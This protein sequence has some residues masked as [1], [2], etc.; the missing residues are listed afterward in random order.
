[1]ATQSA[2][3]FTVL[4]TSLN[5]M[6]SH[7]S[8][9]SLLLLTPHAVFLSRVYY[10]TLLTFFGTD[11]VLRFLFPTTPTSSQPQ[12]TRISIFPMVAFLVVDFTAYLWVVGYVTNSTLNGLHGR[13]PAAMKSGLSWVLPLLSTSVHSLLQ[14]ALSTTVFRLC[15][16]RKELSSSLYFTAFLGLFLLKDLLDCELMWSLAPAMVVAESK[17]GWDAQEGSSQ[18]VRRRELKGVVKLLVGNYVCATLGLGLFME[19]EWA[20][21]GWR[22]FSCNCKAGNVRIP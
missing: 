10:P 19:L 14:I 9:R 12:K 22:W 15:L 1:M 21:R 6:I 18:L 16:E 17:S 7:C 4:R 5:L 3:L 11:P 13:R 8:Y 2:S 20:A